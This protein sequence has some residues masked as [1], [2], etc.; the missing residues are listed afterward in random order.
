MIAQFLL[1]LLL[2]TYEAAGEDTLDDETEHVA[3]LVVLSS[4]EDP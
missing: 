2:L 4:P 1:L 3:T